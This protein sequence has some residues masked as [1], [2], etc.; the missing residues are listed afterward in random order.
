MSIQNNTYTF[1]AEK[2]DRKRP[3]G[4]SRCRWVDN[5]KWGLRV[6]EW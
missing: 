5:I 6:A 3:P 2:I 1:L 4:T